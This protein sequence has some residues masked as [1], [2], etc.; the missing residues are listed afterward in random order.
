MDI[1]II[2]DSILFL[3]RCDNLVWHPT[4]RLWSR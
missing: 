4:R 2:I 3:W 1:F